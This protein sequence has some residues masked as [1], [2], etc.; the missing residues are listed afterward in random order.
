M[1]GLYRKGLF[2]V[3]LCFGISL[4]WGISIGRNANA[5]LDF[6]AV[7]AGTRC[8]MHGHNP[9][10]VGDLE[11]EYLSEGGQ[12]PSAPAWAD[13][14][15]TTYVDAP[16]AFVIFLPFAAL[17]W[18]AA[19]TLWMALT[20]SVLLSAI[21]LLWKLGAQYSA[22][23]ATFLACIVAVNCEAIF[24]G[25]NAAGIVVGL[26]VIAVVCFLYDRTPWFG[27]ICLGLS[28]AIKPHDAGF[29]WLY[30]LFASAAHRKRA[31][32]SLVLAAIVGA[33]G[34][35]WVT[36][37]A[38]RWAHDW[39]AN[40]VTTEAPGGI[41]DPSLDSA[42]GQAVSPVVDL[43]AALSVFG[44]Q[45]FFENI[46]SYMFCGAMLLTVFLGVLRTGFR[47]D[48][49]WFALVSITAFELL[50]TYH[51]PWDAKLMMLAIPPCCMGWNQ[52]GRM[53]R[54]TFAVT[55]AALMVNGDFSLAITSGLAQ[56]LSIGKTGLGAGLLNLALRRPE[57]LTLLAMGVVYLR[58]FR[59]RTHQEKKT[60]HDAG[61]EEKQ[62]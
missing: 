35:V 44:N 58:V 29:V 2:W 34:I 12:R 38:P 30:F 40:F 19:C 21:L 48:A 11:H 37:L 50:I 9:Y 13:Q 6:R 7:Y 59:T 54:S 33:T 41:N 39:Q 45:P 23:V 47:V 56:S 42:S 5:W 1:T 55:L 32:Q 20:G 62:Y 49:A 57:P 61:C 17:P 27:V 36:H 60:C 22:H 43:Q 10:N 15:I 3:L 18:S 24:A 26:C 52:G 51:R 28:L 14:S 25:G 16:T 46:A 4:W 8:L 31:L 53:A